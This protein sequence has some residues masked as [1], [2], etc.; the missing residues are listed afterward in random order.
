MYLSLQTLQIQT[1][2][3]LWTT[4][5]GSTLFILF[6][7]NSQYDIL[8]TEY[9]FYVDVAIHNDIPQMADFAK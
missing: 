2:D 8:W 3:L 6:A 4:L 1:Y 5:S 9:F 7:L